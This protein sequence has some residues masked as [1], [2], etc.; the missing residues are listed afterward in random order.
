VAAI[1][2]NCIAVIS[3]IEGGDHIDTTDKILK[4]FEIMIDKKLEDLK[5]D[6]TVTGKIVK[7]TDTGYMVALEGNKVNIKANDTSKHKKGDIVK[8]HI[9]L[10]NINQ[11][12]IEDN[13]TSTSTTTVVSSETD[14]SAVYSALSSLKASILTVNNNLSQ[15]PI[16][17]LVDELPEDAADHPDIIYMTPEKDTTVPTPDENGSEDDGT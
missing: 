13:S 1:W 11:A 12:Y 6:R 17:Q 8:I 2:D 14:L 3:N 10:D 16:V 7:K 9:P 15:R 4:A 5:Y